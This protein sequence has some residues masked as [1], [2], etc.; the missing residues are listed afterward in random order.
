LWAYLEDRPHG[1]EREAWVAI[2]LFFVFPGYYW[3]WHRRHSYDH[4]VARVARLLEAGISLP[5]ALQATPG[6]VSRDTILAARVGQSSGKLAYCLRHAALWRPAALW[7]Q[8]VARLLY[9]LLLLC[10][11]VSIITFWM[12][13]ILP[14]MQRIF[15]EF[16]EALPESTERLISASYFAE[17]YGWIAVAAFFGFAAFVVLL[18]FSSP[19]RWYL[20][21]IARFYRMH[22]QGRVLKMLGLFLDA[23]KPVPQALGLLA[24]SGYFSTIA[25]W[26]LRRTQRLVEQGEALANSLRRGGLLPRSMAP[27]VQAA[28]RMQNLPWALT[29]LG[30]NRANRARRLLRNLSLATTPVFV[31]II[32]VIVG[33]V[34]LGIFSPVI[35]LISRQ[36]E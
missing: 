34:V 9:P 7:L 30:E 19:L 15:Y 6:V 17:E 20:P 13:Y 2:L 33:F 11:V 36:T 4:K 25:R 26:R 16:H 28:E 3:I 21:I 1:V 8:V 18:F 14:K 31:V 35:E 22:V 12:I 24:S 10:C 5:D 27:L 23:G 29:E 32:G